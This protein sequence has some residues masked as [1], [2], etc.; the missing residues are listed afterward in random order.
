MLFTNYW[1]II[2]SVINRKRT[3]VEYDLFNTFGI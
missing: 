1:E 3:R 2:I